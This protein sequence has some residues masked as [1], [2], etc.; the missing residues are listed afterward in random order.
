MIFDIIIVTLGAALLF[1]G[2]IGCFVPVLPGP[3]IAWTSLPLLYLTSDGFAEISGAWLI[4]LTV[5]MIAV[6]ILDYMLPIWGTKLSG[7]TRAGKI[8]SAVGL[9]VGL[10]FGGPIGIILGPF[11]GAFFGELIAGADGNMALKS[12][13]G[14]F[15]GFLL[16][17]VTKMAVV[18]LIGFQYVAWIV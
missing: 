12:G 16:G 6:T 2:F 14:A 9:I 8:G 17:T 1:I 3:F 11:L 13:F 10:I 18:F 5:L 15:V 4:V 7:G